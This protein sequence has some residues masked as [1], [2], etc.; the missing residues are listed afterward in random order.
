MD[1]NSVV[2]LR[3]KLPRRSRRSSRHFWPLPPNWFFPTV[4]GA[5]FAT[6]MIRSARSRREG[7]SRQKDKG[8]SSS[9]RARAPQR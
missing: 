6:G 2:S 4:V 9:P 7:S 8:R 3:Q 5:W 1:E